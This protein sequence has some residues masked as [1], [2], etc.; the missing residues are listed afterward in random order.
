MAACL[1]NGV[2]SMG[3]NGRTEFDFDEEHSFRAAGWFFIALQKVRENELFP[4]PDVCESRRVAAYQVI[5]LLPLV[6][7]K[8]TSNRTI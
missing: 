7:I 4:T 5:D 3:E 6:M 1:D 8:L 2:M